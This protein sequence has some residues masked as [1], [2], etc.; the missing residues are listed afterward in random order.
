M[1]AG[2]DLGLKKKIEHFLTNQSHIKEYA[3]RSKVRAK[4]FSWDKF[5][6]E[7]LQLCYLVSKAEEKGQKKNKT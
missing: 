1:K 2:D 3:T 4:L 6:R 7:V 5:A